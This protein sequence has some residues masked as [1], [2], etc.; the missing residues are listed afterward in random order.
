MGSSGRRLS[1]AT[2]GSVRWLLPIDLVEPPDGLDNVLGE[3]RYRAVNPLLGV[4]KI[5]GLLE[6]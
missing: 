6:S 1:K 2:S 3:S 4:S 5:G